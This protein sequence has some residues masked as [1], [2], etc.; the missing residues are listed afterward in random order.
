MVFEGSYEI[1]PYFQKDI[2]ALKPISSRFLW[3][4]FLSN[5]FL[6]WVWFLTVESMPGFYPFALGSLILAELVVHLRHLRNLF[7]F[8]EMI[9][10]DSVRGR[11]EYSRPFMLRTSSRELFAFSALFLVL[12]LFI[13]SWFLVGG[14]LKCFSTGVQHLRLSRK[15]SSKTDIALQTQST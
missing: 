12:C 4:L 11:I 2:D 14:A 1:T 8:R 7:M 6:A 5:F 13:P 10:S 15:A 9:A 3:M